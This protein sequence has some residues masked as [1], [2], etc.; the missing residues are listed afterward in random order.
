MYTMMSLPRWEVGPMGKRV[1]GAKS[2]TIRLYMVLSKR[3]K[4]P[5]VK[6]HRD[7]QAL[8]RHVMPSGGVPPPNIPQIPYPLIAP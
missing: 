5:V 3:R 6:H 8:I 2:K 7:P 4:L 1:G